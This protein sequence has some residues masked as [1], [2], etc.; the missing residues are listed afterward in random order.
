MFR[1]YSKQKRRTVLWLMWLLG[2]EEGTF[3]ANHDGIDVQ[4]RQIPI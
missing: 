2:Q 3:K 4:M 1:M